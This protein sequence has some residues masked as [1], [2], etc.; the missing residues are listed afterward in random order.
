MIATRLQ[1]SSTSDIR[2]LDSITVRP[3]SAS[4]RTSSRMSRMPAGSRPVVGSSSTSSFG[5]RISAAGDTQPLLHAV[6]VAADAILGA[7]GQV[8]RSS[9]SSILRLASPPPS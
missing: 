6:R 8:D 9:D 5:L 2:W 4:R 7:I 3:S 1:S